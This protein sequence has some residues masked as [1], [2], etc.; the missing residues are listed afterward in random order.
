MRKYV[1]MGVQGSGKGTQSTMLCRDLDLVHISV[2]DIFRWNVQQ[3]TKVGA[4]VRRTM[5]AG[6][7]VDDDLVERIVRDRLAQHDWNYGF[8]VDGFPRNA[9]QAEFF[10]ESYDIDGV[11]YLDLPDEEVTRRVLSR[12]LCSQCGL[13]YNLI[14]DRPAVEGRCEVC[15]GELVSR[16]DDTPDA[17][18]ARLGD[19]HAKTEPVLETFRRKE[20]V[21]T[22]DAR[23]DRV[24]VQRAIR[25]GLRLPPYE[26]S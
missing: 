11:I 9:R 19:Y 10:L 26:G 12:R 8:L 14:Y 2:G 15:G 6:E 23:P 7:L 25:D 1:V 13:D 20:Y 4:Q 24:S 21:L 5:T 16:E 18:A 22:V 3:H 17:L